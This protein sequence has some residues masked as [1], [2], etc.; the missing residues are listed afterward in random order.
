MY[1]L[2]AHAINQYCIRTG[3]NLM[4][5]RAEAETYLVESL[6]NAVTI[7][8]RDAFD[9]GFTVTPHKKNVLKYWHNDCIDEDMLAIIRD[10]TVI[11]VLLPY[12]SIVGLAGHRTKVRQ[13]MGRI[14]RAAKGR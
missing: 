3:A 14:N 11:T 4:T 10:N 12:G 13:D 6:N 1:K 9:K 5:Q 8:Q 7:T 2:S